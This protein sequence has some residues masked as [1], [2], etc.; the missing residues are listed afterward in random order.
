MNLPLAKL[1][2]GAGRPTVGPLLAVFVLGVLA[3]G[4]VLGAPP[5]ADP[6]AR[7]AT[8]LDCQSL[9]HQFDVAWAA[10]RDSPHAAEAR[11]SR[12]AGEG[13]CAQHHFADGV[14]QLRRALHD[15]GLKP[16]KIVTA[17]VAH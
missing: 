4:L 7:P 8:A 5:A 14:H 6:S 9:L 3:S 11:Q 13:N 17:P 1:R 10:H 15:I 16:V 2:A 12:D